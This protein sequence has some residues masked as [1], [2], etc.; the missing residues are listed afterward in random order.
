MSWQILLIINLI[1]ATIREL[2][3]KKIANRVPPLVAIFYILLFSQIWIALTHFLIY[4]TWPQ[5]NWQTAWPGVLFVVGFGAYFSAIRISLSQSILFQSYSILVTVILSAIFLGEGKYLDIRTG[6]GI[7]VIGGIILAFAALWKLLHV[8]N[9]NEE[10]LE[11]KWFFYI[12]LTIIFQGVGA[13]V[14]ISN[15]ARATPLEV[16]YN[17]GNGMLAV[18][19]LYFLIS[20]KSFIIGRKMI[21]LI[22]I[23]SIFSSMAVTTFYQAILKAPVAKLYPLQQ[24]SLVIL[25]II[26]SYLFFGEK[27]I[28]G[29]SYLKG[30]I[31]GMLGILMLV[32][33]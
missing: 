12:L 19:L 23:S 32:T 21:Y 18:I 9:K 5:N 22:L 33:S 15:I 13:F 25:T 4:R 11:K 8:G 2:F 27:K 14:T 7:K 10:R 3:N 24:V 20:K 16:I 28:L 6:A 26:G 31:L 30:M 17:Q 29:K 1:T